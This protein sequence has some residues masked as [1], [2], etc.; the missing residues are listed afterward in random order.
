LCDLL[1]E[2]RLGVNVQARTVEDVSVDTRFFC[3]GF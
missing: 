1:E 3:E 2:R